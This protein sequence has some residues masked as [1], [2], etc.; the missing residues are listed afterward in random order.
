MSKQPPGRR[1]GITQE[2]SLKKPYASCA[3]N[4]GITFQNHRVFCL[5]VLRESQAE[6]LS[7]LDMLGTYVRVQLGQQSYRTE[8]ASE[9]SSWIPVRTSH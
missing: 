9:D 4:S 2:I 7:G 1:L 3:C 8:T 6:G 5:V